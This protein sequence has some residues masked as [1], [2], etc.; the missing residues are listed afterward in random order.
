VIP[1]LIAPAYNRHDLLLRMLSSIDVPVQRGM[2]FDNGLNLY[3]DLLIDDILEVKDALNLKIISPPYSSI[4]YGGAIN[5]AICQTSN[6]PWWMWASNDIEFHPGFLDRVSSEM[7][8]DAPRIM[9][10][11]FTW[12]AVNRQLIDKVGLIDEFSFHP[13]YFDDNDFEYRCKLAGVE[14]IEFGCDGITHG[15]GDH[16]ASLTIKSDA[17][18]KESNHRSFVQ[19]KNAYIDK[20]GGTPHEEC[21]TSPWN[22]GWPVWVTRPDIDGRRNRSWE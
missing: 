4:G 15:D 14:W 16:I 8:A 1:V 13:I 20:W 3:G 18:L 11:G 10:G 5:Y 21:F 6:A 7:N 12:G 17:V 9:T 22:T 19:N 2:I